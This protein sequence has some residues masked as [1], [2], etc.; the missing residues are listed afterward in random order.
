MSFD[1]PFTFEYIY[2]LLTTLLCV[3]TLDFIAEVT[4]I[5][6]KYQSVV[7]SIIETHDKA[8]MKATSDVV[9]DNNA[10]T[11]NN[12]RKRDDCG[13]VSHFGCFTKDVI[14]AMGECVGID[15]LRCGRYRM[16]AQL[17]GVTFIRRITRDINNASSIDI[18]MDLV[19]GMFPI[20]SYGIPPAPV[21]IHTASYV[22]SFEPCIA[23][24]KFAVL[25]RECL[26]SSKQ[27]GGTPCSLPR[28]VAEYLRKIS[29]VHV[30]KYMK[31]EHE[32]LFISKAGATEI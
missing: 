26:M 15:R 27:S 18:G 29:A 10:P 9:V 32:A 6:L 30:M 14:L 25:L 3:G 16:N 8:N 5:I 11:P 19:L 24:D 4:A 13:R 17:E 7:D 22:P 21:S 28:D 20:D 2:T 12:K 31:E 1:V 23:R